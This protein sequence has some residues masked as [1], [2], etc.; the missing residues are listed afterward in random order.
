MKN[1]ALLVAFIF[2][3]CCLCYCGSQRNILFEFLLCDQ[4]VANETRVLRYECVLNSSSVTERN[5]RELC[6]NQTAPS[7]SDIEFLDEICYN[8]VTRAQ[9]EICVRNEMLLQGRFPIF[10]QLGGGMGGRRRG[11]RRR[12]GRRRGGRRRGR[13]KRHRIRGGQSWNYGLNL[14]VFINCFTQ[15]P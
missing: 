5:A 12:G 1:K 2:L 15:N 7:L 3:A 9:F 11:G 13:G 10:N 4:N 8:L 6:R 14:P